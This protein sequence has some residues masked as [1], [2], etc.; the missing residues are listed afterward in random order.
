MARAAT[1]TTVTAAATAS[2]VTLALP[3]GAS[4]IFLHPDLY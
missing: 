1:L 4:D 3:L 2:A